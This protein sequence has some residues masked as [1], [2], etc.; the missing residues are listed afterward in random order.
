MWTFLYVVFTPHVAI[1]KLISKAKAAS[2]PVRCH[3]DGVPSLILYRLRVSLEA[4]P[5]AAR[6]AMAQQKL[7]YAWCWVERYTSQ[8]RAQILS[9]AR[10]N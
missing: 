2:P 8:F 1:S 5:P 9:A 4:E 7:A 10:H 6:T 3:M